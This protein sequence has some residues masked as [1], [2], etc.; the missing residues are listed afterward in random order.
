MVG[1]VIKSPLLLMSPGAKVEVENCA[2]TETGNGDVRWNRII[3]RIR[4]AID[5]KRQFYY[6]IKLT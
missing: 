1:R 6:V 4:V 3:T 5:V 2:N